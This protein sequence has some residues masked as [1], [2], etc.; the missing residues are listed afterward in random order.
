M[1]LQTQ[2]LD[3]SDPL[4]FS[5]MQIEPSVE[6][7]LPVKS[8]VPILFR[9]Y[10]L[11]RGTDQSE[12]IAIPTLLNE[13]GERIAIT[14]IRLKEAMS[15]AGPSEVVV[16]LRLPFQNVPPGKY[17]LVIETKEAG[18]AQTATLQTDLEFVP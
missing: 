9:I 13:K 3:Q 12:L 11:P 14:P 6:N 15:P 8:A 5:R 7:R 2:L 16:G 10:N 17:R 18:S 1:N 4:L